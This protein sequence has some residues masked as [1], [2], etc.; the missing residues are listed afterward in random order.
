MH[1]VHRERYTFNYVIK[2][3]KAHVLRAVLSR[4]ALAHVT[5][6]HNC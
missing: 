3:A 4:R 2:H 1:T 6:R 5:P